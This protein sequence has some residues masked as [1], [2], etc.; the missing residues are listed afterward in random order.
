M[1]M[2]PTD[3]SRSVR[4]APIPKP[5]PYDWKRQQRDDTVYAGKYT[6]NSAQTFDPFK[7]TP[8][9]AQSDNND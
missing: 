1:Q 9:D 5:S 4:G 7:G 2:T 8:K 6:S 3:L